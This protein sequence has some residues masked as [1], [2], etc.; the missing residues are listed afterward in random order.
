MGRAPRNDKGRCRGT[1]TVV[2]LSF[3]G[4]DPLMLRLRLIVAALAS[5]ALLAG[6]ARADLNASLKKG[7]VQLKSAGAL[8]FGPDSVLFVGDSTAAA[9]F[10][11]GTGDTASGDRKAGLNVENLNGKIGEMLGSTP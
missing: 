6:S 3:S 11:L 2:S 9:I 7:S 4:K 1:A 10:A 8:A 5:A